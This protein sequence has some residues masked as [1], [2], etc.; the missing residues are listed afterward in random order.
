MTRLY[1]GVAAALAATIGLM[2]GTAPPDWFGT[3][4][5]LTMRLEA[6]LADLFAHAQQ[7]GYAVHGTLTYRDRGREGRVDD[8]TVTVRGNT[9]RRDTECSFPKLKVAWQQNAVKIG[10]HCGDSPD[11]T[12]TER[13]GRLANERSPVREAFVYR[14]LDSVGV[15]TL[16]ARTARITYVY[17]DAGEAPRS[18]VRNA[19]IVE[20]NEDARTRLGAARQIDAARFTSAR[21]AFSAEDAAGLAFAEAMIGNFDWCVRF[22]KGDTYRCDGRHPLW[23]VLVLVWPDGRTRPLPYDF[24]VTGMVAG[25]HRWFNDIFNERFIPSGS[26]PAIEVAAQL[27]RARTLF[28]RGVLDAT[29]RRFA[30]RRD[31]AYQA[32][33]DAKIDADGR[34][35]IAAYL[36]AFFD[37]MESDEAFYRPVVTAQD[38]RAYLDADATMPVCAARGPVPVGTPVSAPLRTRGSMV[39]VVPL[40]ALWHY[41]P[42]VRCPSMHQKAVWLDRGA[43]GTSYP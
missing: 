10:T 38:A 27:Q 40:D 32:L 6:P 17:G 14:L 7:D 11:D 41:A 4:E 19:F 35:T 43:V 20:D 15:L 30:A 25:Y 33:A 13:F 37:A 12:V 31:A 8:V 34:A 29:R 39:Q 23:N 1:A 26:H 24:D 16:R 9:S 3:Y 22:F 2:A 36:D 18:I 42:P 5:P 28:D 21:D